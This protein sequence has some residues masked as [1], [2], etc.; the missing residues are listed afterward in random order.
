MRAHYGVPDGEFRDALAD[1]SDVAGKLMAEGR[2]HRHLRVAA[3]VRLQIGSVSQRCTHANDDGTASG[4]RHRHA[5]Q[6]DAFGLDQNCRT[7]RGALND[8]AASPKHATRAERIS[9]GSGRLLSERRSMHATVKRI[10]APAWFVRSLNTTVSH[11]I[12]DAPTCVRWVRKRS[13]SPMS[14]GLW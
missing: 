2:R 4:L 1:C 5:A 13:Q 11:F 14:A 8:H 3:T 9:F 7:H 10:T 12:E 6:F